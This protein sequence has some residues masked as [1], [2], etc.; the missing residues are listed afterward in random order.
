MQFFLLG[1]VR[2]A[3][4]QDEVQQLRQSWHLA[5]Q[6]QRIRFFQKLGGLQDCLRSILSCVNQCLWAALVLSRLS[7]GWRANENPQFDFGS[8]GSGFVAQGSK[9]LGEEPWGAQKHPAFWDSEGP[10]QN[11]GCIE[12][13][14]ALR[15]GMHDPNIQQRC[16][17][18]LQCQSRPAA[19]QRGGS[20]VVVMLRE[21]AFRED[22]HTLHL[23]LSEPPVSVWSW[24]LDLALCRESLYMKKTR[25]IHC[26]NCSL[27]KQIFIVPV[28]A[29]PCRFKN[30]YLPKSH[31]LYF[32]CC[33]KFIICRQ[34]CIR[35]DESLYAAARL[36]VWGC[37]DGQ[38]LWNS[39]RVSWIVALLCSDLRLRSIWPPWD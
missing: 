18:S 39:P 19:A 26:C 4:H 3:S 16:R 13:S 7:Q 34:A 15:W 6:Q 37:P 28:L 30:N 25:F 24:G 11:W 14:T 38:E 9:R 36:G 5:Q 31:R 21:E 12:T 2:G 35:M 33:F 29:G 1:D 22:S 32:S 10:L 17:H 8:I 23:G 20:G 27:A